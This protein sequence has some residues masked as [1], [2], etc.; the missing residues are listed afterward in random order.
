[1]V[2]REATE[3]HINRRPSR[4]ATGHCILQSAP[5]D[6]FALPPRF[7][8]HKQRPV[9]VRPVPRAAPPGYCRPDGCEGRSWWAHRRV[10]G[11]LLPADASRQGRG[12]LASQ[13]TT[14]P[15]GGPP[16]RPHAV[17]PRRASAV[18]IWQAGH[19]GAED[20]LGAVTR[21]GLEGF[22]WPDH[23]RLDVAHQ[24]FQ[25]AGVDVDAVSGDAEMPLGYMR[26]A[27]PRVDVS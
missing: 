25:H 6:G 23:P 10:M 21:R 11:A 18:M 7:S 26:G 1:M 27:R 9:G 17:G 22:V 24:L 16:P 14:T 8:W 20:V 19:Q 12:M 5:K 3:A 15:T 4:E 13:S 2:R